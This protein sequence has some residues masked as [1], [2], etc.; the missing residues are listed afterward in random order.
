M[1]WAHNN[2]VLLPVV[3]DYCEQ[4]YHMF[5][6]IMPTLKKRN[7]FLNILNDAGIKSIFHYVP[8]HS[9]KMGLKFGGK[10]SNLPVTE[11]IGHCLV[12]LPFFNNISKLQLKYIVNIILNC[13]IYKINP[14]LNVS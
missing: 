13:K 7:S 9:S 2:R 10:K 5:Y 11:K 6:M 1:E 14:T 3:P 4:S 12:R 8:L